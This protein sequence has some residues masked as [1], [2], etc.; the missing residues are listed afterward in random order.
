MR[1][2]APLVAAFMAKAAA[3][4]VAAWVAAPPAPSRS[5]L[6]G[7][8]VTAREA[9]VADLVLRGHSNGSIGAV[10]GISTETAKVHRK[11]LYAKLRIS[12]SFELF[13]L[14]T[15]RTA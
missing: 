13:R 8:G 3:G 4:P 14:F 7:R 1:H 11:N 6:D 2:L 9:E 10:L 12:S 15:D 5:W